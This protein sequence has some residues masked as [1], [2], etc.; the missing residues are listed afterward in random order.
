MNRTDRLLAII[1]ELQRKKVVRA[2]DL[3]ATFEVT[4]RSIYRDIQAISEAGVPLVA[5]PGRGYSI[6]EGYF[7][8][9]L[10]FS[11]D[12]AMMLILGAEFV[13]TRFDSQYRKAATEARGKIEAVLRPSLRAEVDSLRENIQF[14]SFESGQSA[15]LIEHL[16]LVRTAIIE[17]RSITFKYQKR[18]S[19]KEKEPKTRTV[20]PYALLHLGSNWM[21]AG[22][23]HLRHDIRSFRLNRMTGL[24]M[25]NRSFERKRNFKLAQ[26]AE[27][28]DLNF[29]ARVHLASGAAR[30]LDESLPY[31]VVGREKRRDGVVLRI[32]T[33]KEEQLVAWIR[34]WGPEATVLEPSSLRQRL[35]DEA[36]SA[37][38]RYTD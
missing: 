33:S 28:R 11:Q 3:A 5:V 31:K 8:P 19:T 1:L 2:G 23:C 22:Y 12:E 21:L 14:V 25:T 30:W 4:K 27:D 9:P 15:T 10:S 7:L 24:I 37:L 29:N 35:K 38:Q 6:M 18:W 16:R 32:A 26:L 34:S 17:K 36:Q 20:D 13:G